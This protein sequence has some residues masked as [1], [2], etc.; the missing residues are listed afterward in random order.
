MSVL[1]TDPSILLGYGTWA[2]IGEGR[3]LID[4]GDIY[5]NG[6]T[7]GSADSIIPYHNHSFSGT[8]EAHKHNNTVSITNA[9]AQG[10]SHS[11]GLSA[12]VSGGGGS[13]GVTAVRCATSDGQA[14]T[15]SSNMS[16]HTHSNKVSITNVNTS[17]TPKGT[18]GYAGTSGNVSGA[19]MP[20][21]FAVCIWYR[22][23]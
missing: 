18:V 10:G 21:Y 19:N 22:V 17:I 3:C 11:H 7:D 15:A 5:T 1:D 23:E 13:I 2:R 6:S 20:P 4:S 16:A 9:G 8:A 12:T 14:S